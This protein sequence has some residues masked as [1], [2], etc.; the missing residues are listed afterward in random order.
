VAH[1]GLEENDVLVAGDTLNDLSLFE[2][3]FSGVVVGGAEA[4]LSE[5][6][7]SFEHVHHAEAPGAGGILEAAR[8]IGNPIDTTLAVADRATGRSQ[9]VVVYHR[10]PFDE[11]LEGDEVSRHPPS[12]PNGIIPTLLG[13]FA[14]GRPGTW[15]AWSAPGAG[16]PPL[17]GHEFV[18][19]ARYQNLVAARVPLTQRDVERFYKRF[20][21]EAF[22]PLMY[23]AITA[24]TSRPTP[25]CIYYYYSTHRPR[26]S[27]HLEY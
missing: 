11:R 18:D 20:S 10:L 22:W 2:E 26:S 6:T 9:L 25:A 19:P 7:R 23:I 14:D 13:S 21:K 3:G 24:E 15:V 5:A 4:A 8:A 16:A 1:L 12:S 27:M 17:P